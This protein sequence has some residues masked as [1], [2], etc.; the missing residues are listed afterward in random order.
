MVPGV[1][2][3]KIMCCESPVNTLGNQ[4]PVGP[5]ARPSYNEQSGAASGLIRGFAAL[6]RRETN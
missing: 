6:P 2:P 1:S 4:S 5:L 3:L